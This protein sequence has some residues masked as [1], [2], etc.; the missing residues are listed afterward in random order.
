TGSE[1]KQRIREI[2]TERRSV[3]MSFLRKAALVAAG[4][5]AIAVPLIIGVVRAQ[6]KPQFEV[7]SIKPAAPRYGPDQ[8]GP[9]G[10]PG[11][12]S[13]GQFTGPNT[14]LLELVLQAY[15]VKRYQVV[16]PAWMN[17]TRFDVTAKI[18]RGT[19]RE[20]YRLM[21]QSLLADRFKMVVHRETKESQVF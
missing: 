8:G 13:P 20:T 9:S 15:N 18:P 11:T 21:M 17:T 12:K 1:L 16:A 3:P 2:L 6:D 4:L 19:S 5:A 14:S 7:A 10:G